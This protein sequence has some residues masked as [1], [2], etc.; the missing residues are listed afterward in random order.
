MVEQLLVYDNELVEEQLLIQMNPD[1]RTY[2]KRK[3]ELSS[4]FW[5][6]IFIN[7]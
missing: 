7:T 2:V 6:T 4:T 3:S 5:Y 1:V